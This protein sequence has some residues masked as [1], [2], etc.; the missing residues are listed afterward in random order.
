MSNMPTEEEIR[1]LGFDWPKFELIRRHVVD[2]RDTIDLRQLLAR[3]RSGQAFYQ[4]QIDEAYA[5]KKQTC[6]DYSDFTDRFDDIVRMERDLGQAAA[7]LEE[8]LAAADSVAA[9]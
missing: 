6:T 8:I 5:F 1:N 3:L 4:G 7:Y 9:E 2:E